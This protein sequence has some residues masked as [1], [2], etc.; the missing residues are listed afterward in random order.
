MV[1]PTAFAGS[2]QK[3]DSVFK[4]DNNAKANNAITYSDQTAAKAQ[5]VYNAIQEGTHVG[6]L[7]E[8][9]RNKDSEIM[10]TMEKFLNT[11][12]KGLQS[13]NIR[14]IP[15]LKQT[16]KQILENTIRT[17]IEII[18]EFTNIYSDQRYTWTAFKELIFANNRAIY[19]GIALTII[20][21]V[22]F[23]LDRE[24]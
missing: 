17:I 21:V 24:E 22:L 4:L 7:Y 14:Q 16:L 6:V 18:D 12:P 5:T 3:E 13:D 15:F 10:H 9:T 11:F 19:I 20:G 23:L 2:Y 8:A 1:E